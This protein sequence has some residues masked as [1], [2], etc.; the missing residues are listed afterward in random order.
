MELVLIE[1]P[2]RRAQE[3]LNGMRVA[4][5]KALKNGEGLDEDI[6]FSLSDEVEKSH[7]PP[8]V[9]PGQGHN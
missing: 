5:D 7:L 6:V 9:D 2:I 1:T 3:L 4:V 8:Y